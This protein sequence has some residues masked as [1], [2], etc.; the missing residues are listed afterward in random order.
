MERHSSM[1]RRRRWLALVG[2]MLAAAAPVATIAVAPALPVRQQAIGGGS[3]DTWMCGSNHNQ[4][5]L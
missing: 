5:R 1:T 2:L 4:V 3:C